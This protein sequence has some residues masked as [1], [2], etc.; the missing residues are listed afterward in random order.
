MDPGHAPHRGAGREGAA[1]AV[2]ASAGRCGATHKGGVVGLEIR[3]AGAVHRQDL[4]AEA[5]REALDLSEDRLGLIHRGAGWHMT[6]GIDR[7]FS[8]GC[9]ARIELG[10]QHVGAGSAG[11]QVRAS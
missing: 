3:R 7:V 6:V 9:A 5:R 4:V 10:E 8:R 1:Y 2:Y 11:S